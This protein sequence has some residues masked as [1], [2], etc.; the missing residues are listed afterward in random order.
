VRSGV[1][2]GMAGAVDSM[3]DFRAMVDLLRRVGSR[4]LAG[5]AAVIVLAI[6]VGA[7]G[8]RHGMRRRDGF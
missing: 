7:E 4:M 3:G 2:V 5:M 6:A 8:M 1:V